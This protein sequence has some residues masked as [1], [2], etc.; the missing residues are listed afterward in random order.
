MESKGVDVSSGMLSHVK[1]FVDMVK[2]NGTFQGYTITTFPDGSKWFLKAQGKITTIPSPEGKPIITS[3][4]TSSLIKGTGKWEG[5]QGGSTIKVK[6][7]AEGISVLD[8]EG[9]YTKK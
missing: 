5:F 1:Q 9:E 3:E 7:I 6:G 4:G 2:G 8:W